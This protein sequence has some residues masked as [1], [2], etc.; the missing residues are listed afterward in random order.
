[1]SESRWFL[2]VRLEILVFGISG[3]PQGANQVKIL[4]SHEHIGHSKGTAGAGSQGKKRE[5]V[6]PQGEQARPHKKEKTAQDLN[7]RQLLARAELHAD[8]PERRTSIWETCKRKH[9][10]ISSSLQQT[11]PA[12]P[13]VPIQLQ[14][15]LERELN[16]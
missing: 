10:K 2:Q 9:C 4:T 7:Q 14:P 12:P 15:P 13:A 1:M 3:D 8:A 16:R 11:C 6:N 5:G